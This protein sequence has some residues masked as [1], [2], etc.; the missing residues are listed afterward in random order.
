MHRCIAPPGARDP[1]PRIG[2]TGQ[3]GAQIIHREVDRLRKF[4]PLEHRGIVQINRTAFHI[5]PKGRP[6]QFDNGRRL[7]KASRCPPMQGRQHWI[8]N[9]LFLI[10]HHG[11]QFIPVALK[12]NAQKGNP[13]HAIDERPERP[14]PAALDHLHRF[15]TSATFG[16]VC[17]WPPSSELLISKVNAPVTAATGR[18]LSASQAVARTK[19]TER[20]TW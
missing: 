5:F 8:A 19:A 10:G 12:A 2:I 13:W 16:W 6:G 7:Q 18:S 1:R 15:G 4:Q 3:A 20:V 11:R 14:V 17:H 9:Q